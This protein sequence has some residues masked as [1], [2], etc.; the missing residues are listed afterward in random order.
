MSRTSRYKRVELLGI[1]ANRL[2]F[3]QDCRAVALRYN[4]RFYA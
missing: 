4:N 3:G 1:L 2:E